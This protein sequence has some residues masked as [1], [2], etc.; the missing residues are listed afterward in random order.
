VNPAPCV[1]GRQ[2]LISQYFKIAVAR[3]FPWIRFSALLGAARADTGVVRGYGQSQT[4]PLAKRGLGG[5]ETAR[6]GDY[7]DPFAT[8]SP[9]AL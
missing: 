4:D 1:A 2:I 8:G 7:P 6:C 3:A 5:V 9:C